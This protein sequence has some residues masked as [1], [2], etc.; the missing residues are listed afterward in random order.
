V[1]YNFVLMKVGFNLVV[2]ANELKLHSFWFW[3]L[4]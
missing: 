1:E 4:W 2:L 3:C